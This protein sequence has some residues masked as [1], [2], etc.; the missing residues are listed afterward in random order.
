[1]VAFGLAGAGARKN[2]TLI[3]FGT[4]SGPH[5]VV[6]VHVSEAEARG[7]LS[8]FS[9]YR[10]LTEPSCAPESAGQT[11][12]DQLD[13]LAK[14]HAEGVLTDSEFAAAKDRLLSED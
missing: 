1:M 14:L 8:Q 2:R 7:F 5:A 6:E 11:L 4:H 9:W 13:Q 10:R 12:A 3:R